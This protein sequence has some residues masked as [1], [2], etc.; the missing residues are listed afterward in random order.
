MSESNSSDE[1]SF[2]QA[3]LEVALYSQIHFESVEQ[4]VVYQSDDNWTTP[5]NDGFHNREITIS[6]HSKKSRKDIFSSR[7][8]NSKKK[9]NLETSK[10]SKSISKN[11]EAITS[12]E[13]FIKLSAASPESQNLSGFEESI[14]RRQRALRDQF[15]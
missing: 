13:E 3:E 1:D 6:E 10:K 4:E 12:T 15:Y 5:C 11:K 8:S 2:D 14:V 7:I 9:C